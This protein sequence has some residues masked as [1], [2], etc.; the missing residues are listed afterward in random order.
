MS[1]RARAAAAS[2]VADFCRVMEVIAP[3]ALAQHWDNVGLLAG[4][5]TGTITKAMLCIDLTPE[6]VD[7]AIT[8]HA[9]I[10]M[11]YHPPIFKPI[12]RLC[13]NSAD[14]DAAVFRCITHG[15]SIYSTHTALDAA[16]GGTNDVIARLCGIEATAPLEYVDRPGSR[17]SKVV[18][19][20]SEK[21][22]E[23]VAE[24]MFATGGGRIG[25]YT[26]CSYRVDGQGTFFGGETTNPTLGERGRMEFIDEVRIETVVPNAALPDVIAA[27]VNAHPYDE[28]AY[29]IYPLSSPPVR[30]IGRVGCLPQPVLLKKLAQRLKR[31]TRATNVQIVGDTEENVSRAVVVVGAAGSLPFKIGV[32]TGDVIITG[33]IR[34]HDALTIRRH[35]C[36]AIALGHWASEHPTLAVLADRLSAALTGITVSVSSADSD[37]FC[38]A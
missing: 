29:D 17:E 37:P 20:V 34:H 18:T 16:D 38:S 31:K 2:T 14:T 9:N 23:A 22:V 10:V 24:A 21:D 32:G 5:P 26:R 7:D 19:F 33:E 4:D 15:I 13:A 35:G 30:G 27:L 25:D 28:P 11:A 3:T 6:V 1:R 8:Q 12:A 36:S